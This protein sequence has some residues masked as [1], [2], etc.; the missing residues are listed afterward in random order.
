MF[1]IGLHILNIV[2][3][4]TR[5]G[6]HLPKKLTTKI[7]DLQQKESPFIPAIIGVLTFFLPCG[8]TQSMQ[9][10]AVASGSFWI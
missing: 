3:S 10:A 7:D 2:P 8:F 1:Y 4:I 9:L 5:F 6:F